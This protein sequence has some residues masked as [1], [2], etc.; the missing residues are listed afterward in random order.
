M[1][2]VFD[3]TIIGG[4]PAGLFAAFY[5]G[6][7]DLST[8]MIDSLPQLGG[9]LAELYPE[10]YIYDIA[11]HPKIKAGD[12]VQNLLAQIEPFH[13]T[14]HLNET[15]QDLIRLDDGTFK[16]I[17]DR[18]AHFSRT[19]IVTAGIGA[20]TPRRL[21]V[22]EEEKFSGRGIYYQLTNVDMCKGKDVIVVG[23]GDS[24]VD[25]ALMIEPVAKSV[26]LV[27]R[28]DQFKAHEESVKQMRDSTV[29][30]KTF[31]ELQ[32]VQGDDVV[33]GVILKDNRDKHTEELAADLIFS[34]LGFTAAL[35]SIVNWGLEIENNQIVVN[36]RM[37]T[38]VPGV[39]AAGDIVTYPGKLKLI[40]CGF[41]EAPI[42]VNNAKTY[43]HPNAKLY[44]GHSSDRKQPEPK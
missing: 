27:H 18:K 9:Q 4:G 17:T 39:Y 11:G 33:T 29:N 21:P 32:R 38:S 1:E 3:T 28:R 14:V 35:G 43:I 25:F 34:A 40:T 19:I 8:N 26:T 30:I 20:F 16:I 6:M 2:N 36:T 31:F 44:P 10:K 37:E 15:V 41:G 24:A 13:P 7:R 22:A 5:A 12:L 42:A 23:G